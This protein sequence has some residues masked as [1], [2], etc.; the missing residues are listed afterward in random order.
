LKPSVSL[1]FILLNVLLVAAIAIVVW[2]GREHYVAAKAERRETLDAKI[3]PVTT[4]PLQAAPQPDVPTAAKYADVA[5]RDL[6]SKDRNPTVV[7]EAAPVE[8]PKEMPPL[9]VVYG[10]MGLPSGVRAL[11]AD[12]AGSPSQPVRVGDTIGEFKIARLDSENVTFTWDGKNIDRKLEDLMNRGIVSS[13]PAVA[14][15]APVPQ[16]QVANPMAGQTAQAAPPPPPAQAQRN[17]P[18]GA[19]IGGGGQSERAC[20]PGDASPPGTVIN[21]Y[22]KINNVSPF[23]TVCRWIPVQ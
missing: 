1:K 13:G 18:I 10:V 8:K 14:Q 17:G 4:P 20:T 19:E 5:T 22:R 23:G 16:G 11:M 7:I 9:P 6:F 3:K 15:G 2:K 12:K 21:G